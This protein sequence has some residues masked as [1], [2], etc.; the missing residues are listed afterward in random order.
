MV[1]GSVSLELLARRT[2]G[3]VLYQ[4]GRM[5]QF[6]AWL[7][8]HIRFITLTNLIADRELMPEVISIGNPEPHIQR[9]TDLL[10]D[11]GQNPAHLA[12]V[13]QQ[14]EDLASTAA[15]TGATGRTAELL[16]SGHAAKLH[17]AA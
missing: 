8:L 1:S 17:K 16:L 10:K 4:T 14:L 3:I 11:W 7:L 12:L 2:P 13:Q 9:M 5:A 15:E 6:A